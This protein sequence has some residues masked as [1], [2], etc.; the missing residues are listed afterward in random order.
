MARNELELAKIKFEYLEF[1]LNLCEEW[2]VS[3]RSL[4]IW[5][6][7]AIATVLLDKLEA[8]ALKFEGVERVIING[9]VAQVPLNQGL[10]LPILTQL[11]GVEEVQLSDEKLQRSQCDQPS[12]LPPSFGAKL[13]EPMP[14]PVT[15]TTVAAIYKL[16]PPGTPV[17]GIPLIQL[18][19]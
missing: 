5:C 3:G 11:D 18:K 15:P 17:R 9:E 14:K 19:D 8:L 4:S 1:Y 2:S 12:L 10:D 13:P 16:P 6:R 7:D